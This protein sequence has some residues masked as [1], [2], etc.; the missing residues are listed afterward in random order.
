M[1]VDVDM[2]VGERAV[3]GVGVGVGLGGGVVMTWVV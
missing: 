1:G 2:S 3:V